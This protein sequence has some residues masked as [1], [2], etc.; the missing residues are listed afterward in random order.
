MT[1]DPILDFVLFMGL[2]IWAAI[3]TSM[4]DDE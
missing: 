1:F 4:K 2:V 3:Y